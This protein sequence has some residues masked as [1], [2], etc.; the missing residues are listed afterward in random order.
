MGQARHGRGRSGLKQGEKSGR[1]SFSLFYYLFFFGFG[2][3]FPLLSVYFKNEVGLSGGEI[4]I[5]LAIGPIVMMLV[6][7]FWGMICDYTRRPN[8]V[9]VFTLLMTGTLGLVYLGLDSYVWMV[10]LAGVLAAFQSA[11]VPISDSIALS[12]VQRTGGDY[13]TLRLWG[14][15]GFAS[16]TWVMG[17]AAE[18][19]GL[20][21]IFFGFAVA[22]WLAAGTGLRLPREEAF[23]AVDL[24]A[25]LSRLIRLRRF[26]LFLLATFLIYGPVHANNVY[27]GLLVQDLGGT[28][29][30]VGLG[31]LLAAG[32]EAPFMRMAGHWI[33]RRGALALALFAALVSGAR[34]LFYTME[35]SITWVYL[36]TVSQ[37]LSVGLFI[38]ASLQYVRDLAPREVRTTAISLYAAA[39]TGLGNSVFTLFGGMISDWTGISGT[40]LLFG[41]SS[42]MG[43]VILFWVKRLEARSVSR[44]LAV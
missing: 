12:A 17:E 28:V 22:L 41:F 35:P 23:L 24:R 29:A 37:G 8:Q 4:G 15:I 44:G 43:A 27:F 9:L 5:I 13:G 31:F 34:W 30:G 3:F 38:P 14:A 1:I 20:T 21:V 19:L 42:L 32:S 25:G 2:G 40:Y 10:V 18:R 6:Q 7:P 36:T 11:I 26:N 33:R 39:G 16:A